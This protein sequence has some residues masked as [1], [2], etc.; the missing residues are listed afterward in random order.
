MADQSSFSITGLLS[1]R[2]ANEPA[3]APDS[4]APIAMDR[5]SRTSVDM[6]E[7]KSKGIMEYAQGLAKWNADAE[8]EEDGEMCCD[9]CHDMTYTERLA[10]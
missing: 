3:P 8:T 6:Q 5:D 10:V 2:P 1:G 4:E 7:A 9:F